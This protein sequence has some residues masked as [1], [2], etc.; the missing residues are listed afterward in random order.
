MLAHLFAVS[1]VSIS[2][3]SSST[4]VRFGSFFQRLTDYIVAKLRT[5]LLI[6]P[7]ARTGTAVHE[8]DAAEAE[9]VLETDL[10][11]EAAGGAGGIGVAGDATVGIG[12]VRPAAVVG[13]EE[14]GG[15]FWG[16]SEE[17]EKKKKE[18]GG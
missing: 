18:E 12:A 4:I 8:P 2:T 9:V 10:G 7:A 17:E 6:P 16:E 13:G 3:T 15:G 1:H 14:G 11:A 5:D